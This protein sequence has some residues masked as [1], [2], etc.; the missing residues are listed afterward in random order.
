MWE[1]NVLKSPEQQA[2]GARLFSSPLRADFLLFFP[3]VNAP[4]AITMEGVSERLK[5]YLFDRNLDLDRVV[6]AYPGEKI[7]FD[8]NIRH[9]VEVSANAPPLTVQDAKKLRDYI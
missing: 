7:P 9:V 3:W 6:M 8:V 2:Q 4:G 1:I 5:V